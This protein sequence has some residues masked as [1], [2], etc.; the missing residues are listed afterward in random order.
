MFQDIYEYINYKTEESI[1]GR[2]QLITNYPEF[3]VLP[4]TKIPICNGP[5]AP[6]QTLFVRMAM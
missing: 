2:F 3:A 4:P 1:R 5:L 6:G